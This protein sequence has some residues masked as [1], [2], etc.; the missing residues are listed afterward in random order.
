M[1]PVRQIRNVSQMPYTPKK[2]REKQSDWEL[3]TD[4]LIGFGTI[5]FL[6]I[7]IIICG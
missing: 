7:V 5:V 6:S 2:M 1:N 4:M 3:V